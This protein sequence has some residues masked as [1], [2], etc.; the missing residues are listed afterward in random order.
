MTDKDPESSECAQETLAP[1]A[2]I[3]LVFTP[4]ESTCAMNVGQLERT[5]GCRQNHLTINESRSLHADLELI[6]VIYDIQPRPMYC[7][8][9]YNPASEEYQ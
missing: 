6:S 3:P 8:R 1:V 5:F 2:I 9:W 4:F 7:I